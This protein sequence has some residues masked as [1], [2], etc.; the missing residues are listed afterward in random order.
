MVDGLFFCTTLTGHRGSQTTFVQP[1]AETSDTGEEV[2][3][4]HP[5]C[6]WKSY[7][8]GIGAGVGDGSAES[9]TGIQPLCIQLV[10]HP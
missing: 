10:I 9:R 2:V 5:R 7:S 1:G 4:L 3:E 6:S 8:I